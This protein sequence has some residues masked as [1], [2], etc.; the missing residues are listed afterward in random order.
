MKKQLRSP[1]LKLLNIG[2]VDRCE[3]GVKRKAGPV[4][5]LSRRE[6]KGLDDILQLLRNSHAVHLLVC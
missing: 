5:V 6:F 1:D 4:T 2:E 3:Q